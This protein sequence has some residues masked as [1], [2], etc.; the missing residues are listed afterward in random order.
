MYTA[1]QPPGA[2]GYG[3]AAAAAGA[4]AAAAAPSLPPL[5]T[6]PEW[7]VLVA[8][9]GGVDEVPVTLRVRHCVM[10]LD[11]KPALSRQLL[12]R[13]PQ[14]PGSGQPQQSWE[15]ALR[16]I[17]QLAQPGAATHYAPEAHAARSACFGDRGCFAYIYPTG[18]IVAHG[19]DAGEAAVRDTAL[20]MVALAGTVYG[21]A[22]QLVGGGDAVAVESL[23]VAVPRRRWCASRCCLTGWRC[24][25]GRAARRCL[26]PRW[27][28][29][30][31]C[32][33][34]AAAAPRCSRG[35]RAAC[36]SRA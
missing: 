27:C 25:L 14:P 26:C 9:A 35:R 30:S 5:P 19:A 10:A 17:S 15:D 18:R 2:A 34:P 20:R 22:L 16:R 32:G 33:R 8:A 11:S 13:R 6:S 1:P 12:A 4:A 23:V 3:W 29:R 21:T 24:A 7:S 28:P 31:C 36:S